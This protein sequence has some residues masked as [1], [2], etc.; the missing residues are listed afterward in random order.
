MRKKI[1][2]FLLIALFLTG[3][4]R[5]GGAGDVSGNDAASAGSETS[6]GTADAADASRPAESSDASAPDVAAVVPEPLYDGSS[7][8]GSSYEL[9][10]PEGF[11]EIELAGFE[12]YYTADDDSSINLNIQPRDDSFDAVSAK[13]LHETLADVLS[14]TYD[15]DIA[16]TDKY[17]TTE[18]VSGFPAY[19][20]AFSYEL[21]GHT[22]T[23]LIVGV[24]ADRIYTFTYTDLS[25]GR[26][27]AFEQSAAAI[28]ITAD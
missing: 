4:S 3:C 16:I 15:A 2:L 27:D 18:S 8:T 24:D 17:F 21:Q 10:I 23:Q 12:C 26:M 13:L 14:K 20:Y 9:P 6:F 11:S 19:Q 22:L 5:N 25:G 1:C 7:H 28:V